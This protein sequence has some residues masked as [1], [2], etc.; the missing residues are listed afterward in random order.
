MTGLKCL[1]IYS[2]CISLTVND[3]MDQTFNDTMDQTFN[4][5]MDQTF[6]G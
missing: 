5:T 1:S 6:F 2:M 3:T 4:D